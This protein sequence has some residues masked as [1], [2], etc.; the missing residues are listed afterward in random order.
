MLTNP[1][2]YFEGEKSPY[3][4]AFPECLKPAGKRPARQMPAPLHP[5]FFFTT[6]FILEDC[7]ICHT[8]P[9][10]LI[11]SAPEGFGKRNHGRFP[12]VLPG[13]F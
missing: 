6:R 7:L 10:D 5:A 9:N 8:P 3:L 12:N 1:L 13:T 2:L 11:L 4:P